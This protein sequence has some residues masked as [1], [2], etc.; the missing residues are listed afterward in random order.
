MYGCKAEMTEIRTCKAVQNDVRVTEIAK[1]CAMELVP[2]E[3]VDEQRTMML[4]DN[5]A[6]FGDIAPYCYVQVGI[7]D[8]EKQTNYAHHNGKFKV[9]EDVLPLC[10]AWMT[11]FAVRSAV[12]I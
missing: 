6:N 10:V 5:F 1:K 9:D 2:P 4:G 8:E 11:S 3:F 7:A 12:E